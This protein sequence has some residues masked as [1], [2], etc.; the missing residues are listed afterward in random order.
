ME[1]ELRTLI[2]R[3]RFFKGSVLDVAKLLPPSHDDLQNL[4]AECITAGD[5]LGFLFV[6]TAALATG[7]QVEARHLENSINLL[8]TPIWLGNIAWKMEGDI[9]GALLAGLGRGAI[10]CELHAAAL[11]IIVLWCQE[12][13]RADLP[14]GFMAAARQFARLKDLKP[15]VLVFLSAL[16]LRLPDDDFRKVL[17]LAHPTGVSPQ[18]MDLTEKVIQTSLTTFLLPVMDLIPDVPEKVLA[19]GRPMQR[20]VPK[21]SRNELC[22]CGSGKKYKRCCFEADQ[23]RLHFSTEVAGHTYAELRAEPEAGLTESR[24][25]AMPIFELE[26]VDPRKVPES[27]L[28]P[29][30]LRVT[31]LRL[32]DR[33]VEVFEVIDWDER[34][35]EAWNFVIFFVMREQ[36]KELAERMLAALAAHAPDAKVD[37]RAGTRLLVARDDPAAELRVLD[38]TAHE[39]FRESDPDKLVG[40]GYGVLCSRHAALGILICRSLIPLVPPKLASFLLDEIG[41]A[42]DR[43]NLPPDDPFGDVVEKRLA[44]ETHDEGGDAAA[45]RDAR[46]RLDA[47]AAEVRKLHEEIERKRRALE[48]HEKKTSADSQPTAGSVAVPDL[49]AGEAERRDLRLKITELKGTLNERSAERAAL[50]RELEKAREDLETLRHG[51]AAPALVDEDSVAADESAHY[52][53]EQP[54]GNQPLRLVEYP[55]KFLATLEDLPRQAA[56]SALTLIGRL[57]GGEPAAF[58]G[59][60]AL[61]ACP[62]VLRQR[63]GAEH[64]LLFRLHADRVQV[65]AL[66]NRRDLDRTIKTLRGG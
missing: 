59:V 29:Y 2:D 57:A 21:L 38:E 10:I 48:R 27:L 55:H 50:R 51:K 58:A 32:L 62:G 4:I 31:G 24:I 64:R 43:L 6:V 9:P 26:R 5:Q 7:R 22:H 17:A 53:P 18:I 23:E 34:S 41:N 11:F 33:A 8:N 60:V 49:S 54:A 3:S 61:K 20:A 40:L 35:I 14:E 25:N 39:I 47:K 30:L 15:S 44:D 1:S 16:A 66:I 19:K 36:R 63:I 56:R 28:R 65:V 13:G 52:L 37:E 45:L 42:R 12:H 46:R